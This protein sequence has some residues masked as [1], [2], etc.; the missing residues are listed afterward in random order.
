MPAGSSV[1][2]DKAGGPAFLMMSAK[3]AK[4]ARLR[5]A[6][7]RTYAALC[8]YR[9]NETGLAFP[10]TSTLAQDVNKSVRAVQ[11]DLQKLLDLGYIVEVG[12]TAGGVR[13]FYVP[14]D[15]ASRATLRT[16]KSIGL[17]AISGSMN[18]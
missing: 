11:K 6:A 5:D 14:I 7:F 4:D 13:K 17:S 10:K 1:V 18:R 9:N 3:A 2:G 12:R 16:S 8:C 15:S